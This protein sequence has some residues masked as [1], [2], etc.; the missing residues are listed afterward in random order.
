VPKRTG[1]AG[2]ALASSLKL[3]FNFQHNVCVSPAAVCHKGWEPEELVRVA[4]GYSIL[5]YARREVPLDQEALQEARPDTI[6]AATALL[7]LAVCNLLPAAFWAYC[8]GDVSSWGW[9]CGA[10]C[11]CV[12]MCAR[13]SGWCGCKREWSCDMAAGPPAHTKQ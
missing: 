2:K 6:M 4:A 13:R 9:G 11:E 1:L 12:Y 5:L 8:L 3:C 7:E 10:V